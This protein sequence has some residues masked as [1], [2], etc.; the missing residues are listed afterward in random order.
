MPLTLATDDDL[1]AIKVEEVNCQ[2]SQPIAIS[3]STAHPDVVKRLLRS[4]ETAQSKDRF[5]KLGF[6]WEV[7][8]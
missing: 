6:G 5:E 3:K 2:P 7:K 1:E 4:L 8:P